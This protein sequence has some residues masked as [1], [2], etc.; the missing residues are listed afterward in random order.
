M[1]QDW[2]DWLRPF[3][4]N[5]QIAEAGVREAKRRIDAGRIDARDLYRLILTPLRGLDDSNLRRAAMVL[6]KSR[7]N[8][9]PSVLNCYSQS[10][11][12]PAPRV[13]ITQV[14][15]GHQPIFQAKAV[16]DCGGRCFESKPVD[17]QTKRL[18]THAALVSLLEELANDCEERARGESRP[19]VLTPNLIEPAI[20]DAMREMLSKSS[21]LAML[22]EVSIPSK[23]GGSFMRPRLVTGPL[24]RPLGRRP[25]GF[26]S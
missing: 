11:R 21:E 5:G 17:R 22:G 16:L 3:V 19:V 4:R 15:V 7:Q 2:P 8:L 18:A 26:R 12:V 10:V 1:D 24:P 23:C 20:P 14:R 6:V 9:A 13:E 25:C